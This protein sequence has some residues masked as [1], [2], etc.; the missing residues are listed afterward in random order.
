MSQRRLVPMLLSKNICNAALKWQQFPPPSHVTAL[1]A[2]LDC[3]SPLAA[4]PRAPV[5][6]QHRLSRVA[7]ADMQK[8]RAAAPLGPRSRLFP[9]F[10]GRCY[11][12][13]FR[14]LFFQPD[15]RSN[16][17][18]LLFKPRKSRRPRRP[19]QGKMWKTATQPKNYLLLTEQLGFVIGV[20]NLPAFRCLVHACLQ[21]SIGACYSWVI[22]A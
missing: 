15:L 20:L 16:E 3:G 17:T 21:G 10:E 12:S 5:P 9:P 18:P 2:E 22:S 11:C 1:Q 7:F 19:K 6:H 14:G 8:G 4:L 13:D